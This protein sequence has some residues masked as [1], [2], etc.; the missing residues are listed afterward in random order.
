MSKTITLRLDEDTYDVFKKA[1]N[2]TRR[3]I[4]NFVEFAAL[5]FLTSDIY[6]SDK[7]MQGILE[8]KVLQR[9]LKQG[10]ADAEHGRY[11][12]VK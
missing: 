7:E 1:A 9:D 10:L 6:V 4:S 2:G 8:D 5:N 12:I 11:R 3:T